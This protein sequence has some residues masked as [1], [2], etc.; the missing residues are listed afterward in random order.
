MEIL[1]IMMP[2]EMTL[3]DNIADKILL[4]ECPKDPRL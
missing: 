2:E 3:A 1:G 4:T